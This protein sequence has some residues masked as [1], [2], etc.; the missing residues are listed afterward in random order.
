MA[1]ISYNE[2]KSNSYDHS[3][4]LEYVPNEPDPNDDLE[5]EYIV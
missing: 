3:K 5:E 2:N 1:Q 4:D